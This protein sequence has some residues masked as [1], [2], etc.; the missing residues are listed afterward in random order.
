MAA[1]TPNELLVRDASRRRIPKLTENAFGKMNPCEARRCWPGADIRDIGFYFFA[2][3]RHSAI[4]A[5]PSRSSA[6]G[7]L[8]LT[9]LLKF[10]GSETELTQNFEEER[11]AYLPSTMKRNGYGSTVRM[12]PPFVAACLSCS[13]EAEPACGVLK[14]ARRGARHLRFQ[15]CRREVESPSGD[16]LRQSFRRP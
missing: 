9:Q 5:E 7:C 2:L 10:V 3:D 14:F 12:V 8:S 13:G 11:R 1:T 15:W 16:T 4:P 6:H